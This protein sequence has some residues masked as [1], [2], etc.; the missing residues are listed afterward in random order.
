MT[1]ICKCTERCARV[2]FPPTG[3]KWRSCGSTPSKTIVSEAI[4]ILHRSKVAK[5][6]QK[7]SF[8]SGW[9]VAETWLPNW[10]SRRANPTYPWSA[11]VNGMN[12]SQFIPLLTGLWLFSSCNCSH[13]AVIAWALDICGLGYLFVSILGFWIQIC[14][15]PSLPDYV[16]LPV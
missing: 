14:R 9:G 15:S 13:C 5:S 10:E 7:Y 12:F 16:V 4:V 11:G 3:S 1:K 6:G 2:D 8:Y